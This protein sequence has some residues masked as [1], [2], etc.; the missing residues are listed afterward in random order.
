MAVFAVLVVVFN[1]GLKQLGGSTWAFLISLPF[2]FLVLHMAYSIY[3]KRLHDMGRSFWPLTAM[4]V[5]AFIV[6]PIIVVLTFGGSEMFSEFAQ[7]ERKTEIDPEVSKALQDSYQQNLKEG[8]PYLPHLIWGIILG[9][10]LWCG[11]SK[12]D[13]GTNKY[14]APL[15]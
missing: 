5:L 13:A 3:G 6:I 9:F 7:Y 14:G 15:S 8:I 11:V 1:W 12:P 2:P 10:T 4:I